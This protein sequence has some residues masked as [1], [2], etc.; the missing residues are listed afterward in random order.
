MISITTDLILQFWAAHFGPNSRLMEERMRYESVADAAITDNNPVAHHKR[1]EQS[2]IWLS[3]EVLVVREEKGASQRIVVFTHHAPSI[4]GTT[5]ENST[6][7]SG[8][9][10]ANDILGGRSI[11]GLQKGD[12]WV[13]GHTFFM[14]TSCWIV[15]TSSRING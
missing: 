3:G 6:F 10:Y 15:S 2:F 4:Y 12:F 7:R 9:M 5:A 8:P 11:D 13:F 1:F 14:Q